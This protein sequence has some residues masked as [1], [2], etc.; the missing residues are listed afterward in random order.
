MA[1]LAATL[2]AAPGRS[3]APAAPSRD[4]LVVGMLTDPLSLDPHRAT[5]LVSAAVIANVCEPLVR[6]RA[7][8]ARH[9]PGLATTWATRDNRHWTLTL[10]EGVRFHDGAPFDADAVVAN[11]AALRAQGLFAGTAERVGPHVVGITLDQ[12]NAALLATLSQPFL[13]LESPRALASEPHRPVG[14][15]PFRLGSVRPGRYEL[16]ADAG[17]WGGAPRLARVVFQRFA[18]ET[19]LVAALATGQADLSSTL[20]LTHLGE[21]RRSP[22]VTLDSQTGLNVAFLSIN[23]ERA[24]FDDPRVRQALQRLVDRP[25]IVDD[26][27]HGH[28][29][30]AD[31]PLPPSLG[32][33]ADSPRARLVDRSGARR[34]LA[35]AGLAQGFTTTLLL[36][37]APRPYLPDP[38]RL[39]ERLKA[40]LAWAG[41]EVQLH[42]VAAWSDYIG[43]CARGDY[44]LAL[45]GWQA[46]SLDP[47]DFLSALLSSEALG[48]TNR[49]RYRSA[50]MDA[51]LKRGRRSGDHAQRGHIYREAQAL[52]QRDLP[53]VPLY[54]TAVFTAY[55]TSVHGLTI[56]PT[57]V[58]RYD[59]AWKTR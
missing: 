51:L 43:R 41:I 10:R 50:E 23:N 42:E 54:H 34:L 9:E 7:D 26:L 16:L 35:R 37:H 46:D 55:R 31:G 49:S 13:S 18:D 38:R 58:L 53:W 25:A 12:P 15:G 27:L 1:L 2:L 6:L 5:D 44:D 22:E 14:T 56:S 8:G 30:P 20:S 21:L 24:P 39:A 32:G 45:L 29:L 28:G 57:G 36:P 47:N 33:R 48:R 11:F 52:F 17:Y 4:T 40:D 3:P 59:K 19:A